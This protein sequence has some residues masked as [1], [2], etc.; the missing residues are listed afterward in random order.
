L[1]WPS[2]LISAISHR[3]ALPLLQMV[4]RLTGAVNTLAENHVRI[5]ACDDAQAF[6]PFES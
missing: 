2:A 6:I 1:G 5:T 3:K 4:Q